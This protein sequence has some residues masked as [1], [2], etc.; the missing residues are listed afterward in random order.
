MG[1][2]TDEQ[3]RKGAET[4]RARLQA[5]KDPKSRERL[6][7]EA[8]VAAR[9]KGLSIAEVA[10]ECHTNESRVKRVVFDGVRKAERIQRFN[11]SLVSISSQGIKVV[12]EWLDKGD[13]DVAMW[14][15]QQTGVVGKEQTNIT[16]N[17][18]NA[19]INTLSNDTLDAA[20]AVAELMRAAPVRR[21]LQRSS[22]DIVV[23]PQEE[24]TNEQPRNDLGIERESDEQQRNRDGIGGSNSTDSNE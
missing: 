12:R 9:D 7:D 11:E 20:R 3:R 13:K 15:L 16:I 2:F 1:S 14:L 24:T 18:Q 8:I 22:D 21:Q 19:Q 4:R 5:A 10:L 17:A 23:N 6:L